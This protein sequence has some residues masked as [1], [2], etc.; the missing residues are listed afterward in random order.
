MNQQAAHQN[1]HR[2]LDF[3]KR[4]GNRYW[5][6]WSNNI[7]YVPPVFATLSNDEWDVMSDWY[8]DSDEKY[9]AG[10]GECNVPPISFIHGLI[11]GNNLSRVV[12]LGHYI[13]F[14]TLLMGF[15]LRSMGAAHKLISFDIDPQATEYTASWIKKA[16]LEDQ[17]RLVVSNSAAQEAPDVAQEYLGGAP[18]LVFLDSSHAYSHTIEELDLWYG[19]LTPGGMILLHDASDFAA[20]YDG[21][22]NGGVGKAARDWASKTGAPYLAL[23]GSV[24][25]REG[26]SRP[27][28]RDGCGLG[29][30]QRPV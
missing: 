12:Q 19:R 1:A 13:G 8:S 17:V 24:T 5:W 26:E 14:S 27:V 3:K 28:Y 2:S 16:G 23:N 11:G 20:Q 9:A 22:N 7:D 30:I 10:T 15:Q 25:G 21:A 6:Y 18:E 4:A 29:I